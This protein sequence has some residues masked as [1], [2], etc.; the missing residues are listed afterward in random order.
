MAIR[1]FSFLLL[2]VCVSASIHDE[3]TEEAPEVAMVGGEYTFPVKSINLP[4]SLAPDFYATDD[5]SRSTDD[6]H[7]VHGIQTADG[8]YVM[9]GK[10][11]EAEKPFSTDAFA[12]KF[13]SK[14]AYVWGFNPGMPFSQRTKF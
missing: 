8:G 12:V 1:V 7:A 11:L 13:D 6:A 3:E 10:G 4:A 14:G 5:M 9:C 2:I